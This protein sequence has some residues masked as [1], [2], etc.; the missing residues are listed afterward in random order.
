MLPDGLRSQYGF[1][2]GPRE[3]Q[4]FRRTVRAV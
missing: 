4:R 3:E 1:A 2:W